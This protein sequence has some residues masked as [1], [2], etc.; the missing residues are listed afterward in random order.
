MDYLECDDM[1]EGPEE[2]CAFDHKYCSDNRMTC[3]RA[4][5]YYFKKDGH[6]YYQRFVIFKKHDFKNGHKYYLKD[7]EREFEPVLVTKDDAGVISLIKFMYRL[8]DKVDEL[9]GDSEDI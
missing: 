8:I 5:D 6:H 1:M 9:G 3:K 7:K 2:Y 4:D